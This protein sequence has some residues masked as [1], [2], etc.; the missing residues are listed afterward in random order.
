L[1]ACDY[2]GAQR[3]KKK[4]EIR[5]NHTH[6][7]GASKESGRGGKELEHFTSFC[8]KKKSIIVFFVILAQTK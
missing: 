6:G 2:R 3:V 1:W 7:I 4:K 5:G 8:T